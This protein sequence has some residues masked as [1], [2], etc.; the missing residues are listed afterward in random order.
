MSEAR[1]WPGLFGSLDCMHWRWKNYLEA[2]QGQ[3]HG[4]VKKPTIILEA[5]ASQNLW[6]WHTFFG[7]PGSHNDINVLQQSPLFARLAEGKAPPCHYT[8]SG[9]EDNMGYYLVDSIYPP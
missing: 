9:Y 6:I 8:V 4:H 2:L 1:G 5:V 3:Y 7:M